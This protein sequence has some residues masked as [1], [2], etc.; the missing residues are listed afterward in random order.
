MD[1]QVF[2]LTNIENIVRPIAMKYGAEAVY[3]FG[4][5]ARGEADGDSDL[6]FLVFGGANFKPTNIFAFA[7]ELR[8]LMQKPVDMFEISEVNPGTDFYNTIMKE[9]VLVA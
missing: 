3:L 1:K 4:S 7:E 9:K 6:D 5:Y 8:E 2:T